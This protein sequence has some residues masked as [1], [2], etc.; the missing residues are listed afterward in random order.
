M[1]NVVTIPGAQSSKPAYALRSGK[2]KEKLKPSTNIHH[3]KANCE[4]I[5][6]M[7]FHMV[8]KFLKQS[9]KNKSQI[10]TKKKDGSIINLSFL[11][12]CQQGRH[13]FCA[14]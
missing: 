12:T 2:I 3:P 4:M 8:Y 10:E 5:K 14:L 9:M 6:K 11:P 7:F 13:P 1:P